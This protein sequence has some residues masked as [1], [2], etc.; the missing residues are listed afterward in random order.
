MSRVHRGQAYGGD[1]ACAVHSAVAK[2]RRRGFRRVVVR[3]SNCGIHL[4]EQIT[5]DHSP[6]PCQLYLI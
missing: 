4:P 1:V 5:V 6:W 2:S 3:R